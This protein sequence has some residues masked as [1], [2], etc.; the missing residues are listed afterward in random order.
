M[1]K[2]PELAAWVGGLLGFWG[3]VAGFTYDFS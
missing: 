3:G 2:P 1:K